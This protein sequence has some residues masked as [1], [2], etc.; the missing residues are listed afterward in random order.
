MATAPERER[1][2]SE[3]LQFIAGVVL[4]NVAV[5]GRLR[6]G[7][8]ELQVLGL[9]QRAG[10]VTAGDVARQTGLTTGSVTGL[11]DR[12]VRAGYASR[13]R[14]EADRR[15]VY[16]TPN[17]DGLERIGPHYAAYGKHL[18][19]VLDRRS[20]TELRVIGDFFAELNA[21]DTIVSPAP[22]P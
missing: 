21:V 15:K 14:D 5:A 3:L 17:P 2:S 20:S 7:V 22:H 11:I 12:L 13:T 6:L 10:R 4:H 8:N 1:V 19:D 16:I 9:A 18:S